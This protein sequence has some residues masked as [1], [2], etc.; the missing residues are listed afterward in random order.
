[1]SFLPTLRGSHHTQPTTTTTT[2]TNTT[3]TAHRPPLLRTASL[4]FFL[5]PSVPSSFPVTLNWEVCNGWR[6]CQIHPQT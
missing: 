4:L 5:P 1:M 3:T 6:K 2:I